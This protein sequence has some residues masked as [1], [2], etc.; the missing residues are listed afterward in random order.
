MMRVRKVAILLVF[1]VACAR[2]SD[3]ADLALRDTATVTDPASGL[4]EFRDCPQCPAMVTLPQ[5]QFMMGS[6]PEESRLATSLG[7]PEASAAAEHPRVEVVMSRTVAIGKYEVTFAEWDFC[8]QEGGCS[9]RPSD[10]RWGRNDRPVTNVARRDAEEYLRWLRRHTGRDYRLPSES[11]WEYAARAGTSTA[12]YWGEGLGEGH[13]VC[14]GCGSRWDN[15]RTAPVGAFMPNGFGVHDMLGNVT[16]WVA[17]CWNPSLEG[18]PADGSA[19]TSDSPWWKDGEC[20]RPVKRGAFWQSF[21][22]TVRA[23][24]RSYWNPGPWSDRSLHYGF[25]VALDL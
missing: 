3:L 15:R 4:V 21:P 20:E 9:Y 11:E 2:E 14:D 7:Q 1:T 16:E 10:E 19:R 6:G 22:W 23:A 24:Y 17:D 12:R 5:G 13:A 25:R 8:F 18:I